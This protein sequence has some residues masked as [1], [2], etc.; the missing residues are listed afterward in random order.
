MNTGIAFKKLQ[1]FAE[2]DQKN[3]STNFAKISN[4][5]AHIYLEE[6]YF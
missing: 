4:F 2:F 5:Y 6:Q 3:L 1:K